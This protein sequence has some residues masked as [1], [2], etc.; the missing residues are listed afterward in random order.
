[1]LDY[2]SEDLREARAAFQEKREPVW[3]DGQTL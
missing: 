3:R 1:M 2:H